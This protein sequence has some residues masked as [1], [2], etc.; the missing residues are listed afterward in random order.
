MC[1]KDSSNT[2]GQSATNEEVMMGYTRYIE[3]EYI[4]KSYVKEDLVVIK[5]QN[6]MKVNLRH[7][8]IARHSLPKER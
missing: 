4:V 7:A 1:N 6:K 3:T 5:F 8:H 2:S